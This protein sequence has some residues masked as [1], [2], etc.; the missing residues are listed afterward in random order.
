MTP[1][2][3]SPAVKAQILAE[4]PGGTYDRLKR[5]IGN[6]DRLWVLTDP[7]DYEPKPEDAIGARARAVD[8]ARLP[9]VGATGQY[10]LARP[11]QR[12]F[13]LVDEANQSWRVGLVA[14][15]TVFDG[16]QIKARAAEVEAEQRAQQQDRGELERQILLEVET[17]R[18]ELES[19]LKAVGSADASATAAGAWE[20][21]S[22]ERYAAGLALLSELLDAQA[23]L[24]A[25][26]AAQ[27]KTRVAAW[28]ADVSLQ[29]VVGQ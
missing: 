24:T 19:A 3:V 23:S 27:V 21:A 9:A 13:P 1:D 8:A 12:Y 4:T 20:E 28:L 7:P 2:A 10:V 5:L 15:W 16:S 17:T 11:N 29:R 18:L 25:A 6:F 14:S 22:S 26:E